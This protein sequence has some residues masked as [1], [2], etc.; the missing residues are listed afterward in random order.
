LCRSFKLLFGVSIREY[1]TR[2]RILRA[3]AALR[4]GIKAD[5]VALDVGFKRPNK[6]YPSFRRI[7]G[8]TPAALRRKLPFFTDADLE[9]LVFPRRAARGTGA[10]EAGPPVAVPA[11][12]WSV[13]TGMTSDGEVS[14]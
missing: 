14:P 5:A 4:A 3:L 10:T 8:Y 12:R 2:Q 1:Q 11:L 9:L 6:F 7:T 13:I